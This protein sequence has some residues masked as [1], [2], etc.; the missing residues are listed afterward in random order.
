MRNMLR[1]AVLIAPLWLAG[2]GFVGGLNPPDVGPPSP[3]IAVQVVGPKTVILDARAL[4]A[5]PR[6]V[7]YKWSFGDGETAEGLG[8]A[9]VTHTYA[10]FGV[11]VVR[12][13]LTRESSGRAGGCSTC[14]GGGGAV[15]RGDGLSVQVV[16]DLRGCTATFPAIT[17]IGSTGDV[18]PEGGA[19]LAWRK[20]TFSAAMPG[21]PPPTDEYIFRWK[22]TVTAYYLKDDNTVEPRVYVFHSPDQHFSIPQ[23]PGSSPCPGV[24]T[25]QGVAV[26]E[27]WGPRGCYW[28]AEAHFEVAP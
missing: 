6:Q 14:P 15:S 11:Y 24:P 2:C 21:A 5:D 20:A 16:V 19:F 18:V 22:V 7:L 17:M 28:T 27:V 9:V 3:E 12:L 26:L 23:I 10:D 25:A 4:G 1:W 13:E 8:L